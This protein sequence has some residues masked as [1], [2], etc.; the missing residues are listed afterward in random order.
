MAAVCQQIFIGTMS[1]TSEFCLLRKQHNNENMLFTHNTHTH[2]MSLNQCL[3]RNSRNYKKTFQLNLM[4][5][6]NNVDIFFPFVVVV[7]V[8]YL[9]SM[10]LESL[11]FNC[12]DFCALFTE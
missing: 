10:H 2:K 8:Q 6:A 4:R 3:E 12:L 1:F 7:G 5:K 11:L 9:I